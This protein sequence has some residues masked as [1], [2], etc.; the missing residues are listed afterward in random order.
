[1][2]ADAGVV[3][4][5][6]DGRRVWSLRPDLDGE[7]VP[8]G[9]FVPWPPSLASYLHGS[10]RVRVAGFDDG[11]TYA[12]E[13]LA[14]DARAGRV[15]VVDR[16][17]NPLVVNKVGTLSRAFDAT[18]EATRHEI[19]T[20]T[21]RILAD[22]HEAGVPAYLCYG[23]LLG[24]MR[25]GH[26]I[27]HDCDTDLCYLSAHREPVDVIAE[28]YRLERMMRVRGWTTTRMSGGDFKVRLELS[29]GRSEQVD[30]FAAFHVGHRF[31]Q[32]GNR[33]GL[34]TRGDI[35]PTSTVVLEGVPFHAPARPERMLEFLYGPRWRVP[36]PSFRYD[37]PVDGVRRLDGWLRGFRSEQPRWNRYWASPDA[38]AVP[39]RGSSFAHWVD[40]RMSLVTP[41][42]DLGCGNGRDSWFFA[43]R[44]REV[45]SFDCS[46]EARVRTRRLLRRQGAPH[47]VRRLQLNELRTVLAEG[48]LLRGHTVYARQLLDSVDDEARRNLWRLARLAGGE[49]FVEFASGRARPPDVP[50]LQRALDADTVVAEAAAAGG[51]LLEREDIDGTDLD[52]RPGLPVTRL[53]LDFTE[54]HHE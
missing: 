34:L 16:R 41:V 31:F 30:V 51:R 49:V 23:A 44:R 13:E 43:R 2:P 9:W 32:L 3:T 28:S 1:V 50:G 54:D 5:S 26:V 42:A 14:F 45:R 15:R 36:D 24:A 19:L 8:A 21:A 17:G 18:D 48:L 33:S 39:Q 37:D 4:V 12:D 7:R 40:A 22:L 46:P 27:G 10:T 25:D 11:R 6:F 35:V 20:G 53:H 47:D 52:D 38:L 29:D